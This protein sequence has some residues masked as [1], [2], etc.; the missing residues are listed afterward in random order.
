MKLTYICEKRVGPVPLQDVEVGP[1]QYHHVWVVLL[2]MAIG[3][4]SDIGVSEHSI[5]AE[6]GDTLA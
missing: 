3:V 4:Y 1:I 5:G 6:L 2:H